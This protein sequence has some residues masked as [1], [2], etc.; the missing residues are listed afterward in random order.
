MKSWEIIGLISIITWTIVPFFYRS[1]KHF[2][3][4]LVLTAADLSTIIISRIFHDF[5]Q[6]LWVP[7]VYLS[8]AMVNRYKIYKNRYLIFAGLMIS[9]IV[10]INS[11]VVIQMYIVLI[12]QVLSFFI[13]ARYLISI[14]IEENKI[15]FFYLTMVFYEV[16]NILKL[17]AYLKQLSSG[18]NFYFAVNILQILI[19]IFLV[20]LVIFEKQK[21][22]EIKS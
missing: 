20:T 5:P 1:S 12:V 18:L 19:G 21:I 3:F 13:F 15:D 16:L 2:Y 10:G 6:V 7:F 14:F 4:F 8:L 9:T 17:I 22:R 11:S